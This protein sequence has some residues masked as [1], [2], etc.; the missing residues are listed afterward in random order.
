MDQKDEKAEPPEK[1]RL[2]LVSRLEPLSEPVK[3]RMMLEE[4]GPT[5]V[6]VGQIAS[7]QASVIPEEWEVELE[8]LQRMNELPLKDCPDCGES[9]LQRLV[10]AAGFRLKG[11][12]WYET[13]FKS[14]SK[15]N[16]HGVD[17]ASKDDS[18]KTTNGKSG[19]SEAKKAGNKPASASSGTA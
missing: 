3:V 9:E 5:Y 18:K 14:G 19:A 1:A 16:L 12:G 2:E 6:K 8:K 13:D 15:K 4:L 17:S 10:S 11:G 7:S